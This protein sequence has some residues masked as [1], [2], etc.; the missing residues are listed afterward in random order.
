[1]C[2]SK[3]IVNYGY[4]EI[5]TKP[6]SLWRRILFDI[7]PY[8]QGTTTNFKMELK[9]LRDIPPKHYFVITQQISN[10]HVGNRIK[11]T[12]RI[13]MENVKEGNIINID[14]CTK[15]LF[16]T[17]NMFLMIHSYDISM[18]DNPEATIYS[19]H[20]THRSWL[21]LAILAGVIAGLSSFLF[22]LAI[23]GC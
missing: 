17:G 5:I 21:F 20:V 18:E 8:W 23:A 22:N 12:D 16:D 15:H 13:Y 1:M 4:Y 14:F 6:A 9:A 10:P 7:L 11:L 19:F 3:Q 2:L